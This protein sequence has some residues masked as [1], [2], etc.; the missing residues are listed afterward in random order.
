MDGDAYKLLGLENGP[1]ATDVE[2]KKVRRV[3]MHGCCAVQGDCSQ[4]M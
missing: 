1:E 4:G 3:Q 2:I